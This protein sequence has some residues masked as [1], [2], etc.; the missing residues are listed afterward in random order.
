VEAGRSLNA[1]GTP[2]SCLSFRVRRE[3]I[4]RGLLVL[5]D[6]CAEGSRDISLNALGVGLDGR[7][8]RLVFDPNAVLMDD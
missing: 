4:E 5:G 2:R 3:K 6:L 7:G 8:A 1:S